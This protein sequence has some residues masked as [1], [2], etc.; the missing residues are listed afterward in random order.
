MNFFERVAKIKLRNHCAIH[1]GKKIYLLV[2]IRFF[3]LLVRQMHNAIFT[4]AGIRE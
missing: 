2:E 4:L 3:T 1:V